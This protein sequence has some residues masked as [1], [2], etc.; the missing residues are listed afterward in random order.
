MD[1]H[2]IVVK[3][4]LN[5]CLWLPWEC[6]DE[7]LVDALGMPRVSAGLPGA[8]LWIP[9][10]PWA[11]PGDPG[12]SPGDPKAARDCDLAKCARKSAF[13]AAE[14]LQKQQQDAAVITTTK[15]EG[16]VWQVREQEDKQEL[17]PKR[18]SLSHENHWPGNEQY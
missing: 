14:A 4:S 5:I 13:A 6:L 16:I 12:G 11:S 18:K 3:L 15:T 1:S 8:S 10:I 7:P 17:Y 9:W 2:Q